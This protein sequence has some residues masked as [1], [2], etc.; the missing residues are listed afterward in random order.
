MPHNNNG[1]RYIMVC[2][3]CFS[4]FAWAE[5]LKRKDGLSSTIALEKI[6]DRMKEIPQYF[7]TDKGLEYYDQRV[8]KMY[9]RLG[10]THYSITG[11][12]KAAIAERFIR[13][14]KGRLEKYFWKTKKKRWVDVLQNFID[15]YNKTYHRS[16]KMAP[17]KVDENNRAQVFKTLYPKDRLKTTPRLKKG[18][19]V[20]ILITKNVF[21]KGYTRSWSLEI[22]KIK[23]A[24]SE[25][26]I[27][28]YKVVDLADNLLP[29]DRYYWQL[30][31]VARNDSKSLRKYAKRSDQNGSAK[32]HFGEKT[33]VQ[34][35]RS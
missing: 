7:V 11:T 19:R 25:N 10:I 32:Y 29:R 20:R 5:P 21:S 26:G 8:R 9:D 17:I 12:H 34:N 14:I 28:Y 15:N 16:I 3:C 22:Y 18:D 2:I 35:R 23:E 27:D 31:L 30:N 33:D 1:F 6:F 24:I 4:K 13:T